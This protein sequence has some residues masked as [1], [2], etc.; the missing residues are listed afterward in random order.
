MLCDR[1]GK[2]EATHHDLVV[3]GGQVHETHLCEECARDLGAST[4]PTGSVSEWLA[5]FVL[6]P[7]TERPKR[8]DAPL[9]CEHCGLTFAQFKKGG[10]MGCPACYE[11]F[12][13]KLVPLLERAHEG[14]S[15]HC[16]K[17]P[18]RALSRS[19]LAR[20]PEPE[21]ESLADRIEAL[22][23]ELAEAVRSEAYEKA[24]S[25]RD[26]LYG[27]TRPGTPDEDDT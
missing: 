14:A 2:R 12:A 19:R 16:G 26:Q 10:L 25:I 1:C 27:L 21:V 4:Q 7:P 17:V 6:T 23:H 11:A 24:A 5:Q 3:S 15:Q 8:S 20:D 22:R 13:S 18:R 9:H